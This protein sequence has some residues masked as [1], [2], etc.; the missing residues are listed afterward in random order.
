MSRQDANAAFALSSFLQGTNATYIDEIYARYEKDP[1]SVD[2]DWQE[3]F[4][5]L[6]DQPADVIKNA[7]GP[8]WERANWPLSPRDDLTS[9]LDGNWA[10]VEKAVGAKV[11]AKAQAKAVE[12]SAADINQA[13]RDSVRA[14]MLIRAY[15]MRGHFHAKLDPLGIEAPRNRE[16]LDPR[17]Y[18]FTEADFDRKIFLDHVLGL[19][20]GT[21]REIVAICERTYCQTLGVEFMHI[22][23][24]AQKA[25]IQ[26][27]IEGPDKE[28]S[29]TREG[30]RAI[31]MKL[32]E[33]EGFEKFC[34]VKFTGTKR[35]GLDGGEALIPALEQII[36]RG[37]NLGVKEIVLGMPHRGRLNVLTQ[38]LAKPHRAL[39]HEFKGGSANPDAVE[40]S[41]DVKYH[42]GASS[43]REF[44][45]NRIHLS[46]TANPSHLEIVDPVVLGKVRAKQDQHGDPPDMRISVLPLLM[47]GDAAFAGQGV[48]AECFA[49]SDLKGYRTGGSLHFIVNNQI[50]FTTYPR[51]SR[52]SPYPS[53]VAKMI[54]APIFHVNGDDP[55][56]VVFAAKVA[57]EFRQKFHKPVVIDMFCYRRHGHNEGD[58]P[59][60]TQPVMYKKIGAH[61]STLEIYAKRLVAEGVM[62]EGEVE[63]AKAD[64]RARLDAEFEAG[65]SYRPNKADWLDG[66]WAGL[67]SA[68]QEEEA[69]RGVTGVE[70]EKLKEIGRKIT[71]VPDGFRVHRTIQ[72]FLEN[73]AK[74]IES[75]VGLDWAT[76]EALAF[77]AL[78]LEG[79]QVRLSGQDCERGTFSQR[80]SVLIDQEDESRYTPFNHLAPEQGHFEVINSLLSE[81]AVLGF[82]YGYSL[83]EPNA[84]ACWEAQ[85]GDFANG[86][87]VVFD[88]FI[89]SGER[90]WLR[91]SG[92]VCMLPHGYEGQGPEHSSARLER[93][94]QLCAEDNM[95]VVYPTTPA[96]YFHVLRRQ[97]HRE[98]RKPLIL[99]TPKS[100][101]RHKRAV[102]RLDE[103]AKDTTF[104]R[105]LYDDA[106][107]QPD[108]KT[109][110]VPDDQI[111]R[112]VLCSGKVYYDLYDER[113]KRGLND[114]YLMR[115]EQLYPV[116]LKALVTELSRFK[117]AEVVW[118]QEE[119]RNMGAWHFIEPYLE[120]VLNQVGGKSKRPRYAGRAASAATATGLMSKHLAQLKAL[121]DDALN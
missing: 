19:E 45:G 26:E 79:H 99:M 64:W 77:C 43:D 52:S 41:G 103:L 6:K 91:M 24:A 119:P 73:R 53:D 51:Y 23:N 70:I 3:F 75:G 4:K 39:F 120:W 69:R 58:E 71:K 42:L 21:L 90:K 76:G 36:K 37:G 114:V 110:L 18:G 28:I 98:I 46:L 8:S 115:V 111:R 33:A 84:L 15:R 40:G 65:A 10:E 102:S 61:P 113:E 68:D 97:L 88:Q 48:V 29:F 83:A 94:L 112:I 54:D 7:E 78:L 96:N 74:A 92:L 50:G 12:L 35:F 62:T 56:A 117:N 17:S 32:V 14:L 63:K 27:R 121:L 22:S 11:A 66:K 2:P 93:Y 106:Q 107:M 20:Y 101:L 47:H 82:E 108:D 60:F 13:T 118:C 116:P 38:V 30:R 49:L 25:W 57:T 81:E 87:Q 67:K 1:A 31:L 86:A 95:Q 9:A 72:R 104:H 85:F 34:D 109:R 5:S 16:E 100:L 44:D 55:E 105:I 59:A 80:H 89:S